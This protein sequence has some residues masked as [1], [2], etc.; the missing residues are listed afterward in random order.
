MWITRA[1]VV[2]NVRPAWKSA[3]IVRHYVDSPVAITGMA[4]LQRAISPDRGHGSSPAAQPVT[5]PRRVLLHAI[6]TI[7]VPTTITIPREAKALTISLF[8]ISLADRSLLV[9]GG[10]PPAGALI[11]WHR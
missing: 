8:L 9:N 1:V 10:T 5:P 7:H 11:E 6:H 3:D 2:D 4:G